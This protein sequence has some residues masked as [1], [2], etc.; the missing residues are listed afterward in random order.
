MDQREKCRMNCHTL[1]TSRWFRAFIVFSGFYWR[2]RPESNRGARICSPLRNHS[3]TR[4]SVR[5]LPNHLAAPWSVPILI[6][7]LLVKLLA[8]N[9]ENLYKAFP[10]NGEL[11][12]AR[13]DL[14]AFADGQDCPSKRC[15]PFPRRSNRIY[16]VDGRRRFPPPRALPPVCQQ[17][18]A[19]RQDRLRKD[20]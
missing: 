8:T 4:P 7:T 2:P 19:D 12:I 18:R 14:A 3:A 20:R 10:C 11:T 9:V 5:L 13:R 1:K 15:N 16:P 6:Q 17:G